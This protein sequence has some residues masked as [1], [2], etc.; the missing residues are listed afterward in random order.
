MNVD[1]FADL[2]SMPFAMVVASKRNSG[3]TMFVSQLIQALV[4]TKKVYV[5]IVYSNTAH[6]NGDYSF[7]PKGLVRPFQPEALKAM[8]DKQASLPKPDRKPV[9]LVLDDIL[10]DERATGNKEILYAYAM[11]R[12]INVHPVLISQTANRVLT[13]AIR[14]NAD[15]FVLSRLNRQQLGEVWESIT[16]MEKREFIGFVERVNK[17]FT[18]VVVDNTGNSNEPEDFLLLVRAKLSSGGVDKPDDE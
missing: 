18:F 15:Y 13:P 5:P 1:E 10:G 6:L 9:L 2:I 4:K 17:H 16:N 3:K 8:L 12:H 14:N 7:L 11:G